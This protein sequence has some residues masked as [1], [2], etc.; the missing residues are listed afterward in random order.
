M[1]SS[2]DRTEL[3]CLICLDIMLEPVTTV[4]GKYLIKIIKTGHTFCKICLIRNLKTKLNCPMCRDPIFQKGENMKKNVIMENLIKSKYPKE[5]EEKSKIRKLQYESELENAS[6]SEDSLFTIPAIYIKDKF[7]FP[8]QKKIFTLENSVFI[9]TLTTSSV[10]DR[11]VILIP[12]ENSV[13]NICC[14]CELVKLEI[15]QQSNIVTFELKGKARFKIINFQRM[16]L[17]EE[18]INVR[19]FIYNY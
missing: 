12:Y 7:V 11:N 19:I 13:G 9:N 2:T 6:P 18:N 8:G 16:N 5:Y 15:N 4:C 3:E 1:E 14:F 10:N 17:Q